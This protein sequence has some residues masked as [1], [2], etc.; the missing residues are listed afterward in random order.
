MTHRAK[1]EPI[2]L[3]RFQAAR[4]VDA[5]RALRAALKYCGRYLKLR[6][7][8]ARIDP[9]NQIANAFQKLRRDSSGKS[10]RSV[11]QIQTKST[12]AAE[13][14]HRRSQMDMSKYAS[15]K[16]IKPE[17]L[18]SGPQRKTIASIE[19]GKFDKPAVTFEDGTKMSLNGTNVSTLIELFGST[20]HRDWIGEQIELYAGSLRYAG[21]DNPAV[22]VRSIAPPAAAKTQPGMDD[23]IPF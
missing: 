17:D 22:L 13:Q 11:A 21:E 8:D 10:S 6:A 18:A 3:V 5:V 4:G 7:I 19:E 14:E 23:K 15:R 20:E 12:R 2:Y 16:F 9:S 1:P